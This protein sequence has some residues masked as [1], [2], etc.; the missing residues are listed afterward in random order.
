[1]F[2]ENRMLVGDYSLK[3]KMPGLRAFSIN[4][5]YRVVYLERE[6]YFTQ[7]ATFS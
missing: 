5:D 2:L 6:E 4:N 1:M 7:C 3:G